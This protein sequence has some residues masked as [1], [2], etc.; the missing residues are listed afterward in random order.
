MIRSGYPAGISGPSFFLPEGTHKNPVYTDEFLERN[1]AAKFSS[2]V[3][4][5]SAFLTKDSW[6]IIVPKFIKGI[7]YQVVQVCAKYGVSEEKANFC[8]QNLIPTSEI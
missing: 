6:R 4:T 5:P 8:D 7:R 1:G 2:V 3:M